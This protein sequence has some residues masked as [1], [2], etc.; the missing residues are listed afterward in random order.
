MAPLW[1]RFFWRVICG[2]FRALFSCG[3]R[4]LKTLD[5]SADVCLVTGAGQGLG[6]QFALQ[7]AE[8][9]ATLVL[10]DIDGEKVR[11][12]AGEIRESGREAYPYVVDI[13]KK[14]DVYRV[15][16][17]VRD[18]VGD[19]AVLINN[20]AFS[21]TKNYV[22]GELSDDEILR[23]F[24]VNALAPFWVRWRAVRREGTAPNDV[25]VL[26]NLLPLG[27]SV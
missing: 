12:V 5:L 22:S 13:S 3:R 2:V 23:S 14:E 4:R 10:W 24:S 19:V 17:Q 25:F 11:A 26:R 27:H 16:A 6:R 18:E 20:A 1:M 21:P 8:C 15:A 7:L 9:G